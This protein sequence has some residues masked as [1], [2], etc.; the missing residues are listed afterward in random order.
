M[1]GIH[2]HKIS[3]PTVKFIGL[4]TGLIV[5]TFS[6]FRKNKLPIEEQHAYKGGGRINKNNSYIVWQSMKNRCT[7]SS[8]VNKYKYDNYGKRGILVCDRW[9]NS[10]ENFLEDMGKR[11]Q[12]KTID[13]R[14][15]SKGYSPENCSWET[16]QS[17]NR[18]RRDNRI[19]T[20]NG[21]SKVL[22]EWFD[23]SPVKRSTF[24]RRQKRG[25]SERESLGL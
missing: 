9:I 2:G 22:A 15:N 19:I 7:N 5:I 13:R 11:P 14:D 23:I 18:N 12:N 10:F 17:Q 20:I 4:T 8:L 3:L 16:M 21:I 24:Y 25:L 1:E 6:D